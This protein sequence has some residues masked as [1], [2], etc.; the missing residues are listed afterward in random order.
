MKMACSFLLVWATLGIF[1]S[2]TA[3]T[4][5]TQSKPKSETKTTREA[6]RKAQKYKSPVVVE[7]TEELGRK[8][9]RVSRPADGL[10][11]TRPIKK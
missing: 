8:I 3:Q 2:A 11:Q 5:P 9:Q 4:A 10:L 7:N 6:N 1:P